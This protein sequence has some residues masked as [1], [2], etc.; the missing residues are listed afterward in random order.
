M[1]THTH[2][3]AHTHT[4][5]YIYIHIYTVTCITR[6]WVYNLIYIH[7]P[8]LNDTGPT[9]RTGWSALCAG[10]SAKYQNTCGT[11]QVFVTVNTC[12]VSRG[13]YIYMYVHICKYTCKY[14]NT[15]V[16]S[17]CLFYCSVHILLHCA[18]SHEYMQCK[19]ICTLRYSRY[20]N[21][22]PNI[23]ICIFIYV[24][25]HIYTYISLYQ[26]IYMYI[27]NTICTH[28]AF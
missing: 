1:R 13:L 2:A 28:Y 4:H 5:M 9:Q 3:H 11:M 15:Y 14:T 27:Y 24:Y 26:Y 18:L 7:A 10:V 19:R 16:V 25:T 20:V 17:T 12:W 6:T 22:K 21:T 23:Y 8:N